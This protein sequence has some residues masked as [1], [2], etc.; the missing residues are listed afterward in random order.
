MDFIKIS[1]KKFE[2]LIALTAEE[3]ERGLMYCDNPPP[4]MTFIYAS[5]RINKFWMKNVPTALDIVFCNKNKITSIWKGLPH[6]TR[7][8][9]DDSLSEIIIELPAG[10]C[11]RNMLSVGSDIEISLSDKSLMKL[12][13]IKNSFRY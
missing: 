3:Q 5:P 11:E 2:T 8:I 9:G 7:I 1:D 4:I 6:S 12:L 13:F 10:T